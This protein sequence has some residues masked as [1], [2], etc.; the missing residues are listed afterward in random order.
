MISSL[1]TTTL[2]VLAFLLVLRLLGGGRRTLTT[3]GIGPVLVAAEI[4]QL[5]Q[6]LIRLDVE[7]QLPAGSL[8][9]IGLFALGLAVTSV[10]FD[11]VGKIVTSVGVIATLV[12]TLITDGAGPASALLLTIVVLW[13]VI[14]LVRW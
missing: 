3:G 2:A 14:W 7:L 11:E 13:I 4:A 8:G 6:T 9:T 1:V 5:T 10:W 12:D